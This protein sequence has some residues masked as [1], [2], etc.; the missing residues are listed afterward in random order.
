MNFDHLNDV[1]YFYTFVESVLIFSLYSFCA[2]LSFKHFQHE[3]AW[4]N[5]VVV[6]Y[7]FEV[8]ADVILS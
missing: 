7:I 4:Q 3:L 6:C 8:K 1:I 5:K 2:G